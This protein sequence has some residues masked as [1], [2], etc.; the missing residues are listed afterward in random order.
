MRRVYSFLRQ[1]FGIFF[2]LIV[3]VTFF[4]IF[5]WGRNFSVVQNNTGMGGGAYPYPPPDGIEPTSNIPSPD[6][7]TPDP[8]NTP[9]AYSTAEPSHTLVP[10]PPPGWPTDQP[11]PPE[12]TSFT[13]FPTEVVQPFPTLDNNELARD[14]GVPETV[15]LWYPYFPKANVQPQMWSVRFDKQTQKWVTEALNINIEIPLPIIGP[16]PGPILTD[17]F[18]SPDSHWLVA[19]Y[20]Y[21]GSVLIDLISGQSRVL[22]NNL[23]SSYW[24][25]ATWESNDLMKLAAFGSEIPVKNVQLVNVETA[26]VEDTSLLTSAEVGDGDLGAV[27]YS[28]DGNNLALVIVQPPTVGV[29]E[30]WTALV[31]L[32]GCNTKKLA[33]IKGGASIIENG[34]Q[35]SPNG[36]QLVWAVVV[37]DD[38]GSLETQLWIADIDNDSI[39]KLGILGKD[40]K[41]IY[42]SVWSPDGSSVAALKTEAK[43]DG[44]QEQ[45]NIYLFNAFTG[46][47]KQLTNFIGY[48]LSH[49]QWLPDSYWLAFTLSKG[50][51]GE[52]WLTNIDGT[53]MFPFAGPTLPNAPYIFIKN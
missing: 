21:R 6:P 13:P 39:K 24:K 28:P 44:Q 14:K 17:F 50:D 49:L 2:F 40:V 45:Q 37:M 11:W 42:P 7:E 20:A 8:N 43:S 48:Q 16:D 19:N 27:A 38:R 1:L 29:R 25:F 22:A 47:E 41:N 52:I 12:K 10:I 18:L 3:A 33:E 34:L 36:K 51:Y 9:E 31:C 53:I 35:W 32:Q 30:I 5:S 46:E 4:F 26:N 23:S 15:E